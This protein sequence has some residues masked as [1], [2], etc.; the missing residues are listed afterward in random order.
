M[1]LV[2]V[3]GNQLLQDV[4]TVFVRR[5]QLLQGLHNALLQDLI[6]SVANEEYQL[7]YQVHASAQSD[8]E[9]LG[10]LAQQMVDSLSIRLIV[11]HLP[12]GE[13]WR[14]SD[15]GSLGQ[16]G[17]QRDD[18]LAAEY[19]FDVGDVC[20][21]GHVVRDGQEAVVF[22]GDD[23]QALLD[24]AFHYVAYLA[25]LL[26][27]FEA[28]L[29]GPQELDELDD[30]LG[31][32]AA[33]PVDALLL[34]LQVDGREHDQGHCIRDLLLDFAAQELL[35]G[36]DHALLHA[37]FL[38]ARVH[39]QV[40]ESAQGQVVDGRVVVLR[41]DAF[42]LCQLL[43]PSSQSSADAVL[44]AVVVGQ[45]V[46]EGLQQVNDEVF[47]LLPV[48]ARVL[49]EGLD[50]GGSDTVL[51]QDVRA[52][53]AQHDPADGPADCIPHFQLL[54]EEQLPESIECFLDA[55]L[56]QPRRTAQQQPQ[57]QRSFSA[58]TD[59]F[60]MSV[61]GSQADDSLLDH[62][63]YVENGDTFFGLV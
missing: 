54:V 8:V 13:S 55:H 51:A 6:P 12:G 46:L 42:G 41:V 18:E 60:A 26:S 21:F 49:Q 25:D 29:D 30:D 63:A 59:H 27:F 11:I 5:A 34:P 48:L 4:Q 52:Q 53:P 14:V 44:D 23:L 57:E 20:F 38:P 33:F 45:Q 17:G 62:V 39:G 40:G 2:S 58:N 19:F 28:G 24:V 22:L 61:G 37:L 36:V 35:G 43:Q 50:D 1:F 16:Q 32:G 10:V 3:L 9:R 47:L 15:F 56:L 31:V 7:P